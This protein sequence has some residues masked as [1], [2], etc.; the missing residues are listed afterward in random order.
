MKNAEKQTLEKKKKTLRTYGVYWYN[1]SEPRPLR[2]RRRLLFKPLSALLV[3]LLLEG[4]V[5]EVLG[6]F[7]SAG[8][9][10]L[11]ISFRWVFCF[12]FFFVRK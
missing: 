6:D 4:R 12:G 1:N 7:R 2:L 3:D 10:V 5:A 9:D 8:V 11:F